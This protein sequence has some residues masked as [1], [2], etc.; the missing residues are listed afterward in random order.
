LLG[1]KGD[2]AL[3]TIARMKR[4]DVCVRGAGIVG[5]SL[6]LALARIG[7]QVGLRPDPVRREG[8]PDV[9]AYALNANSVAL[10]R[11][12]KVWDALPPH[13]ATPVHDMHIEGDAGEGVLEFSAWEARV[14][15]LAHIVDAAV[16]ER[17][18]ASALRFAPHVALLDGDDEVEAEL[19]ALCEGKASASR[20][21]HGVSFERVDYGHRAIAARLTTD[22]DHRNVARQWF[23]SPD[24]LALLPFDTPRPN[25]SYALVWSLPEARAQ[26][27]LAMDERAFEQALLQATGG[28]AGTLALQSPRAAWPLMR[29]HASSVCGPGWVLLGDAAH[30]V[31]PL[32][33]QG[34]NLGLADVVALAR[35][36]AEREPWRELGD[37]KLLRRYARARVTPTWAMGQLTDG[38]LQLFAHPAPAVRELRNRGMTLVNHLSPLKRWLTARALDS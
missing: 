15:E 20:E 18:L 37:E 36:I 22:Q 2:V 38:L 3:P 26:A 28:A 24:V 10:L 7:L 14:G 12:L 21:A 19:V 5:Q 9:R 34:L 31:H 33:G 25:A 1:R 30:V 16:L 11:S 17:E 8:A 32:A 29:G 4:F 6:A 35:V 23:R 27:L 13:A